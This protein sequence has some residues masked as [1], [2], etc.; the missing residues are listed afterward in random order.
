M[1]RKTATIERYHVYGTSR[2]EL[3]VTYRGRVIRWQEGMTTCMAILQDYPARDCDGQ[4]VDVNM[5]RLHAMR[6]GFTHVRIAGDWTKR[7][8]PAGGAV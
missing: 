5:A 2:Y 6:Q 3:R 8:K 4:P 7:T 1:A